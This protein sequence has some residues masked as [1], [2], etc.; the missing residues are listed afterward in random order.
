MLSSA[1]CLPDLSKSA[2]GLLQ[3]C[4][5]PLHP[6]CKA[7]EWIFSWTGVNTPPASTIDNP[8]IC[9]LADLTNH[10]SLRDT[11]SY[12][13][14]LQ[15][16]HIFCNVFS[17]PESQQ[18]PSSF[19]TLHSF[20]LWAATDPESVDPLLLTSAQFEPVSV[21]IAKKYLS[22]VQALHIAQGWPEPLTKQTMVISTGHFMAS[23]TFKAP[24]HACFSHQSH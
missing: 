1:P 9:Y 10:A 24:N 2:N 3:W 19:Q 20:T 14:G 4:P 18:L 17:I 13:S 5:S 6:N 22:A 12:G 8:V 7:D 11:G 21:S 23:R 15:K 16:F